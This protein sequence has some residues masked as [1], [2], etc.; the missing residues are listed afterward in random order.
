MDKW[1]T[2]HKRVSSPLWGPPS[3]YKQALSLQEDYYTS[4][5]ERKN[6]I[7]I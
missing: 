1:V 4:G 2:P 5:E 6:Q 3:L 7:L